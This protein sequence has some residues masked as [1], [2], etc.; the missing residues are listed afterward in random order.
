MMWPRYMHKIKWYCINT[1]NGEWSIWPGFLCSVV[2]C[3]ELVLA[4]EH[5]LSCSWEFST[6]RTHSTPRGRQG[7]LGM[8]TT[9]TSSI[10]CFTSTRNL[11]SVS[12]WDYRVEINPLAIKYTSIAKRAEVFTSCC[13]VAITTTIIIVVVIINIVIIVVVMIIMVATFVVV[14]VIILLATRYRGVV[15]SGYKQG[16]GVGVGLV[17]EKEMQTLMNNVS[18]FQ[19]WHVIRLFPDL[20][21]FITPWRTS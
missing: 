20:T 8:D 15:M 14:F 9:L 19:G 2:G 10:P 18:H 7:T 21:A 4:I 1:L 12:G 16:M 6:G 5:F 11:R 13:V 3:F 17:F